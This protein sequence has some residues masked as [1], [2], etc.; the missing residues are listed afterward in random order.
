MIQKSI[1]PNAI[2]G[3]LSDSH[4]YATEKGEISLLT[5]CMATW[6]TYEIYCTQGGLFEDI[7]RYSTLEEAEER[8]NNI[9]L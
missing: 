7:E 3:L 2:E 9:L 8:I 5:P 4:M 1:I 6:N